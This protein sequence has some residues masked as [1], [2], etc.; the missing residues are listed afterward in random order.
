M[1][2]KFCPHL[3]NSFYFIEKNNRLLLQPCCWVQN[4][5]IEIKHNNS[6]NIS[7]IIS[8]KAVLNNPQHYCKECLTREKFG[9]NE[10]LRSWG[11]KIIP[12]NA[13]K[14][15]PYILNFN[16]DNKCNAACVICTA[17]RSSLWK[18]EL[19]L[20]FDD[21]LSDK[22]FEIISS[23][24][25]FD[26][27]KNIQFAGGEP[28]LSEN[29]KKILRLIPYPENVSIGYATNGSI[30]PDTDLLN[31]WK[32][33]KNIYIT[34]SIDGVGNVFDYIRWPLK[35]NKVSNNC[36]D[37]IELSKTYNI[38]VKI[39]FTVNPLN[40]LDYKNLKNWVK[41]LGCTNIHILISACFGVWGTDATP[42]HIRDY[43]NQYLYD[44]IELISLINAYP[45]I[46]GKYSKLTE[47]LSFLDSKRG[48]S[49]KD[50]FKIF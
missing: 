36:K 2:D 9:Y 48:T 3:D 42:S 47:N 24:L 18:K 32:K 25:N 40:I 21:T 33:F 11:K 7:K 4:P 45:E 12:I 28:L 23:S 8:K 29:Y 35:W 15:F 37:Y 38:N 19:G 43:A 34:F 6:I 5:G 26:K 41:T 20:Y 31:I 10:S 39:N 13:E 14:N 50:V 27:V 46:E 16:F 22:Y 30:Y 1:Q 49:Y 17:D 44:E